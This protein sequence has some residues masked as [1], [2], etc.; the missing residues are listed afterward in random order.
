[1]TILNNLQLSPDE[2][3]DKSQSC[4]QVLHEETPTKSDTMLNQLRKIKLKTIDMKRY[5]VV[6]VLQVHLQ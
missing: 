5:S 3:T 6:H 1:M 2:D 4:D